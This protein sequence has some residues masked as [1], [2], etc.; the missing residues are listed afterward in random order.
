VHA[1]RIDRASKGAGPGEPWD[2]FIQL[3]LELLN[4]S[5]VSRA[6]A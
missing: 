6:A 5:K 3:G 4:E 1:A 2:E